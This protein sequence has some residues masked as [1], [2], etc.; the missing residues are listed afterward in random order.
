LVLL[1]SG[2][3]TCIQCGREFSAEEFVKFTL[4]CSFCGYRIFKKS[5]EY[6]YNKRTYLDAF[7]NFIE[8]GLQDLINEINKIPLKTKDG[9]FNIK[10]ENIKIQSPI[11]QEF[12][13]TL[14]S[15][16]VYPKEINLRN[17]TY[18]APLSLE[19]SI[20]GKISQVN[21]GLLPVMVKSD[22][23]QLS[24]L[25]DNEIIKIGEDPNDIGGYFIVEGK[26]LVPPPQTLGISWIDFF[27][28]ILQASL[29]CFC[30][31]IALHVEQTKNPL[32]IRSIN[33]IIKHAAAHKFTD[34][35]LRLMP[36]SFLQ[37]IRWSTKEDIYFQKSGTYIKTCEKLPRRWRKLYENIAAFYFT[38]GIVTKPQPEFD[39][40]FGEA[41]RKQKA[42]Q[43]LSN[44]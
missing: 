15:V 33:K 39:E 28:A 9:M 6:D 35:F 26:R 10:L 34:I 7:N 44:Y 32:S 12:D 40:I 27:T 1:P 4:R 18:A 42:Y 13:G 24:K 5:V 20:N 37:I 25:A 17:T 29:Q 38:N 23:C 8:R 31:D 11:I 19:I 41:L 30:R 36:L 22:V 43:R 14:R 2:T 3:Y 21:I 16:Y